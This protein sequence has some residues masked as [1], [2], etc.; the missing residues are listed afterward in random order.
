MT[1]QTLPI[2]P[3][4]ISRGMMHHCWA[5]VGYTVNPY[6]SQQ[7]YSF[8]KQRALVLSIIYCSTTPHLKVMK[9]NRNL[10][11]IMISM[12]C[13]VI[14]GSAGWVFVRVVRGGQ[15]EQHTV[16]GLARRGI[17]LRVASVGQNTFA[18][19]ALLT[20]VVTH[21]NRGGS[22]IVLLGR[23]TLLSVFESAPKHRGGRHSNGT[24]SFSLTLLTDERKK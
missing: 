2:H 22:P 11:H 10:I 9:E 21:T 20:L 14:I 8:T 12:S 6:E 4:V 24:D 15:V 23:S 16:R 5:K 17:L 7:M 3:L 13:R 1:A 18:R 19:L